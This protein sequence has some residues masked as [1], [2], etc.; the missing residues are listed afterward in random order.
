MNGTLK[1]YLIMS[2]KII[3][4]IDDTLT[5][6][7]SNESYEKKL[8]R[9]DLIKKLKEYRKSGYE[10]IL[11]SSRNMKTYEGDIGKINKFTLPILMDWLKKNAVEYDGIIMGK[12]WCGEDGFYI[13]DKSI[14]PDEFINF[15]EEKIKKIISGNK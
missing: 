5:F 14:R 1:I 15:S 6:H 2:K 7:N 9:K 4:D 12:P 10:I 3:V 13:D 8:P 11:Y